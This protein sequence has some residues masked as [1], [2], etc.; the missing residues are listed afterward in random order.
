MAGR[1]QS[2]NLTGMLSDIGET[3][4][5]MGDAYKPVLQAA[6][7]PRG[8]MSDPAHLQ[9]LA[10]WATQNGDAAAASMYMSQ[11][12]EAKAEQTEAKNVKYNANTSSIS[13]DGTARAGEGDVTNLDRNIAMLR[14]RVANATTTQTQAMAQRALEGAQASRKGAVGVQVQ[15]HAKAVGSID[16]ALA[17]PSIEGRKTIQENPDGTTTEVALSD[18]LRARK[19]E[20]LQDPEVQ[21]TINQQ[22]VERG[23][24][25]REQL[26]FEGE[27]YLTDNVA[28]IQEAIVTGDLDKVDE[29]RDGANGY[30]AQAAVQAYAD[31]AQKASD[32]RDRRD[33]LNK[34]QTVYDYDLVAEQVKDIN[35]DLLKASGYD[36]AI[37]Q[38]ELSEK[39]RSGEG[40]QLLT[41]GHRLQA[42]KARDAVDKAIADAQMQEATAKY[43]HDL[44]TGQETDDEIVELQSSLKTFQPKQTDVDSRVRELARGLGRKDVDS[45]GV[46]KNYEA[47]YTD[48]RSALRTEHRQRV[49]ARLSELSGEVASSDAYTSANSGTVV[50]KAKVS[51]ALSNDGPEATRKN[52]KEAG[53][54]NEQI[55][56]LIAE[57]ESLEE[58]VVTARKRGSSPPKDRTAATSVY[59]GSFVT[60][61]ANAVGDGFSAVGDYFDERGRRAREKLDRKR[62]LRLARSED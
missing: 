52:L 42:Q 28:A 60:A 10:Q 14:E 41:T 15:N 5:S 33:D 16:A 12:R 26:A 61:G 30:K 19:E 8:D 32:D 22:A 13:A 20:L 17:D 24:A 43:Q 6:T 50:T 54:S 21:D 45:D 2:A 29:I 11:A 56:T 51:A 35:P 25:E 55:D 34:V 23:R 36:E 7:K 53:F 27:Q 49:N 3:V 9:S 62:Q 58:V 46:P 47:L 18:S 39:N 31:N 1:D 48:A 57:N 38:V 44:R 4:G 59:G 40:K 37:R